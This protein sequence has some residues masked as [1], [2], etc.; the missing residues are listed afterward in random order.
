MD[1]NINP[2]LKKNGKEI[3]NEFCFFVLVSLV[4]IFVKKKNQKPIKRVLKINFHKW[5]LFKSI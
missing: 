4:F 5:Q 1:E 2:T 3:M